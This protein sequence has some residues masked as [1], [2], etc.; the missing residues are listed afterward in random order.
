MIGFFFKCFK[1]NNKVA[2]THEPFKTQE[3]KQDTEK[4]M[5]EIEIRDHVLKKKNI[6]IRDNDNDS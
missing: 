5:V 6:L 4:E 2:E 3:V 1:K